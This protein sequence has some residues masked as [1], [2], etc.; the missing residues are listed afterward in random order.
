MRFFSF[1]CVCGVFLFVCWVGFVFDF[2][3]FFFLSC[4]ISVKSGYGKI[5]NPDTEQWKLKF[6]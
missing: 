5:G 6:W 4:C 3:L 1:V 2:G